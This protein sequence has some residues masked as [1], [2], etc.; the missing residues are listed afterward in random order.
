MSIK[1]VKFVSVAVS[2][3]DR[4]LAFW[5]DKI[6]FEVA[7]DAPMNAQDCGDTEQPKAAPIES[8]KAPRWIEMRIPGADTGLVL[9]LGR[10][11]GQQGAGPVNM[12]FWTDDLDGT[13]VRLAAKGVAFET[14]PTRQPWGSFA[15]FLDPDGNA[16]VIGTT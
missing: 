8:A 2:D 10:R 15:M 6:G 4:A 11:G 1:R 12:A 5:R 3:Q 7:L 9:T 14:P 16:F 13:Y